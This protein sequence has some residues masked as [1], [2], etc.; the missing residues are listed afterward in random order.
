MYLYSFVRD[1]FNTQ[2]EFKATGTSTFGPRN[3]RAHVSVHKSTE[4]AK[5]VF[6]ITERILAR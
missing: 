6:T 5:D 3:V 2:T 4:P 1:K